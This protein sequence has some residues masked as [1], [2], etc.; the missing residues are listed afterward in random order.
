VGTILNK[1]EK[2]REMIIRHA[3]E[4]F[5]KRGYSGAS[6]SEL[7]EKTGLEKGGIYRHFDSKEELAT[8]AFDYAW[9]Q[10]KQ[11]RLAMLDKIVTP[12]GKLRGMVDG[13]LEK[14][15]IVSGGCALM[16]TAIDA[17]DG[18]P[19]LRAHALK[20]L[21]EWLGYIE[22]LIKQGKKQGEIAKGISPT[23]TASVIV[24]A[25]EG[26]LMI[27]RL[28]GNRVAMKEVRAHLHALLDSIATP[29]SL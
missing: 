18:N 7:M 29:Q 19:A 10:I 14:P 27:S 20:A 25:L 8:E 4:I 17:D 5:N 9:S 12:M 23:R 21:N 24:A 26:G 3:A 22:A 13:F 11:Y 28:S 16:N 6:I 15:T 2:T 1:G